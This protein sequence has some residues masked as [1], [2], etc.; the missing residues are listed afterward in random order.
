[1][2]YGRTS[3]YDKSIDSIGINWHFRS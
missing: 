2:S 3:T 1:L